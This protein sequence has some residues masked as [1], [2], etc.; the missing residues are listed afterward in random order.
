MN[1]APSDLE[2][3][4]KS[5]ITRIQNSWSLVT[6]SWHVLL[7]DKELLA[8]PILSTLSLA[9]VTIALFALSTL[10]NLLGAVGPL[11]ALTGPWIGLAVVF[12]YSLS[13]Y[14]VIVFFN[15]ALVGAAMIRLNGGD[16]TI[17]DGLRIASSRVSTL[18]GYAVIGATA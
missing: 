18:L 2:S 7:E 14:F 5:M 17:S 1:P 16:P 13:Q 10:A 4:K 15:T 12:L 6:S 3:G 11:F 8:Y 9:M